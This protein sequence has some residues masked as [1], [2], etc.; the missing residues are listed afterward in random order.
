MRRAAIALL[1]TL[2]LAPAAAMAAIT[3]S[4]PFNDGG[5]DQIGRGFY[6][7]KYDAYTLDTATLHYAVRTAG[8]YEIE[9]TVT[10]DEFKGPSWARQRSR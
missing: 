3:A 5:G 9:L 6:V 2:L 7:D 1:S 10:R 4:C 8:T